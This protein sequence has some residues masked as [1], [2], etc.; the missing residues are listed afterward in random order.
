VK[1]FFHRVTNNNSANILLCYHSDEIFPGQYF[2]FTTVSTQAKCTSIW[3][4]VSVSVCSSVT[5]QHSIRKRLKVDD[6]AINRHGRSKTSFLAPKTL[7]C[8]HTIYT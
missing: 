2:H 6:Y 5:S 7:Q 3:P 1:R 4:R 8:G